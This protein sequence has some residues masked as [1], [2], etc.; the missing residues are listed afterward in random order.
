MLSGCSH[1]IAGGNQLT[2]TRRVLQHTSARTHPC[3]TTSR[4]P[5]SSWQQ[6]QRS[7]AD[8]GGRVTF[9]GIVQQIRFE[10]GG[11]QIVGVQ[12]RGCCYTLVE[13]QHKAFP[14]ALITGGDSGK[15]SFLGFSL[16]RKER[17]ID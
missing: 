17:A 5:A 11:F 6:Q 15:A 4:T 16:A 13:T 2:C 10:K 1:R 7:A 8:S 12:V 9:E 14:A 3:R